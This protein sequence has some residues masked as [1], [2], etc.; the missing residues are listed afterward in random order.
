MKCTSLRGGSALF[1][2]LFFVTN[3]FY[4]SI[5]IAKQTDGSYENMEGY[6][7]DMKGDTSFVTLKIPIYREEPY[8]ILLQF[9]VKYLDQAGEEQKLKAKT[10]K[11]FGFVF[12]NELIRMLSFKTEFLHLLD[13]EDSKLPD[14]DFKLFVRYT[15]G[16]NPFALFSNF[17]SVLTKE[18]LTKQYFFQQGNSKLTLI[19][20]IQGL[21]KLSKYLLEKEEK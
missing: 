17:F 3:C 16:Q 20:N 19:N 18:P 9:N 5:A 2:Y 11:S 13:N 15:H 10:T 1:V 12:H 6:Y 8:Y 7:V 4:C 14:E 21:N